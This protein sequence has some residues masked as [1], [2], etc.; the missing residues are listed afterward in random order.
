MTIGRTGFGHRPARKR[1]DSGRIPG[2]R[3][4]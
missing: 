1:P 3:F 4:S 2:G